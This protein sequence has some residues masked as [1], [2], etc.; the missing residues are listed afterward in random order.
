MIIRA[1]GTRGSGGARAIF[2][3]VEAISVQLKDL[4]FLLLLPL[5][6]SDLPTS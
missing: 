5:R 2:A 1:V 6:F 4:L 3:E